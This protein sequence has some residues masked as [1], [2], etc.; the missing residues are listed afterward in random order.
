MYNF[1]TGRIVENKKA[2]ASITAEEQMATKSEALRVQ[3]H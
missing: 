1:A 2:S 3:R